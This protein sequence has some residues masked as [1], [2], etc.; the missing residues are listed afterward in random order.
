MGRVSL[1]WCLW[2]E[3]VVGIRVSIIAVVLYCNE[4]GA[5]MQQ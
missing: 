3:L 4:I 2:A 5:V 1:L